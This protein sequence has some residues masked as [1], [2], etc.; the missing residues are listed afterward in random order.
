M[1]MLQMSALEAAKDDETELE[2][3]IFIVKDWKAEYFTIR[4]L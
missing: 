4:P 3:R 1:F 2:Q